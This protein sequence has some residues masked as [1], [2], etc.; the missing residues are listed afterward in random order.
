MIPVR[1]FYIKLRQAIALEFHTSVPFFES[2]ITRIVL[3]LTSHPETSPTFIHSFKNVARI[4][5][6]AVKYFNQKPWIFSGPAPF[7]PGIDFNFLLASS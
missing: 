6:T 4:S 1:S 7:Q 5:H 3:P 2:F